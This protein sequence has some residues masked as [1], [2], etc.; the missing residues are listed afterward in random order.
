MNSLQIFSIRPRK[1]ILWAFLV[2]LTL[3]AAVLSL[4]NGSVQLSFSQVF[5]ALTGKDSASTAARD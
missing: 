1:G 2:A 3:A 4:W 5:D